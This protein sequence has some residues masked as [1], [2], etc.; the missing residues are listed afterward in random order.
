MRKPLSIY[1]IGGSFALFA[2]ACNGQWSDS[3]GRNPVVVGG[4]ADSGPSSVDLAAPEGGNLATGPV[5][6]C[7][8]FDNDHDGEVDEGIDGTPCTVDGKKGIG[9]ASCVNGVLSCILCTPGE[10]RTVSCGCA[11][12]RVDT[13]M[14][15]GS[16]M[17][18]TCDGCSEGEKPCDLCI[19]GEQIVR[20][21]DGCPEGVD[22][23]A[24]CIGSVWECTKGCKWEQVSTCKPMTPTCS[25]DMAVLEPCGNCGLRRK[26]CDGCFWSSDLCMDQGNC[27][28]GT[29]IQ[30][31][32][33]GK[34]CK[35]GLYLSQTCSQEC[36]W[37]K[38]KD[39]S[40][41]EP[42]VRT[43]KQ[44]C[45]SGQPQCGQ[46]TIEETCTIVRE[47]EI[48]GGEKKLPIGQLTMKYL[49]RCPY[50]LCVPGRSQTL[51]CKTA[52]G[53]SGVQ[54]STCDNDCTWGKPS[55]CDP[56]GTTCPTSQQCE[57][58]KTTEAQKSCGANTCG[59]TYTE[60]RT[61]TTSGCGFSVTTTATTDCP[62]CAAGQTQK[63]YCKT[64]SGQCGYITIKCNASCEWENKPQAGITSDKC[65]ANANSCVPGTGKTDYQ[66]CGDNTCGAKYP[67]NYKCVSTGCGWQ[68][69]SEDR[70][71]CPSCKPGEAEMT[72][73][74]C[75]EG[76]P[77]CGYVQ[78]KCNADTCQWQTLPC[79]TC[80]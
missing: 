34:N 50:N 71:A 66:S 21:C 39:C 56:G 74:L 69:V 51:P 7:D 24:A 72:Q 68:F 75:K 78:R 73:T 70:S 31:P 14:S 1:L 11:Q 57:A 30:T 46:M 26:A 19:P 4:T 5:E 22:C 53:E 3:N 20:R 33:F 27:K 17:E 2:L 44:N 61:C 65:V 23:G 37:V 32:C 49:D 43:R 77:K 18:G 64:P 76:F 9:S 54:K 59:K 8:G 29:N 41:C 12:E 55:E 60:K 36:K 62:E 79:P 15:D 6:I 47:T 40:G 80:G 38:P 52:T 45:V 25:G 28:P 10:Q 67:R 35:E 63:I 42:G 58:N 16:W 13:C 48:C